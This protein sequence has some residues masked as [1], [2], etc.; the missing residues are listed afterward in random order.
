M[1]LG[2][3]VGFQRGQLVEQPL[4]AFQ[5]AVQILL[6]TRDD[7]TELADRL[8]QVREFLFNGV[9]ARGHS[10]FPENADVHSQSSFALRENRDVPEN[11]GAQESFPGRR[12]FPLARDSFQYQ[13]S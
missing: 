2:P 1:A 8:L 11:F 13:M 4:I 3:D 6:L 5:C 10:C 12:R 9:E 7:I